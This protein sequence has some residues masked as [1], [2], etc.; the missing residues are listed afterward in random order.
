[1]PGLGLSCLMDKYFLHHGA[2]TTCKIIRLIRARVNQSHP[3]FGYIKWEVV[4][5]YDFKKAFSSF[6]AARAAQKVVMSVSQLVS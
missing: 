3:Q 6:L 5:V 2:S 4:K 1:M